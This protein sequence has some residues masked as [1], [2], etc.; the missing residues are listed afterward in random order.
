MMAEKAHIQ[1]PDKN[2]YWFPYKDFLDPTDSFTAFSCE[3]LDGKQGY[4]SVIKN[5]LNIDKTAKIFVEVYGLE[6]DINE[7][8]IYADTLVIFSR[9]SL[10]EIKQIFNKPKDIFPSDIVEVTALSKQ[11][12][13]VGD[14]G[15]LIPNVEPTNNEHF[16][17]YCWW[18]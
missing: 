5:L 17:Y 8:F 14:N 11:I 12:F 4:L 10:S 9:L 7:P 6:D 3:N 1:L 15:N 18:D 13:L 16:I 2:K